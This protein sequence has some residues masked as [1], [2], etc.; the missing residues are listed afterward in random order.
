MGE[1]SPEERAG[2]ARELHD[3]PIQH[4]TAASL[5]LQ[6][7]LDFSGLSPEGVRLA[8]T[9]VDEAAAELRALMSR[10]LGGGPR[11]L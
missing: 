7:A 4:L 2:I 9:E 5:R 1:L 6:S 11:R 10:L 8:L 3:G